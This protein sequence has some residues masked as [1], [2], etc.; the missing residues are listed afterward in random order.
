MKW[1][2]IFIILMI[3]GVVGISECTSTNDNS[4]YKTFENQ[5]VK[6]N[7]SPNLTVQDNSRATALDVVLIYNGNNIGEI[8]S[9]VNTPQMVNSVE[10]AKITIAG[11]AAIESS[12]SNGFDTYIV[13]PND[14]GIWLNFDPNY[15]KDYNTVKKS[16][17]IKNN[18]TN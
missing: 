15:S 17:I 8:N 6:F 4:G 10:G 5:F 3:V 7:Y 18:P 13:L 11:K 12:N 14:V 2:S 9:A 1:I 16:L